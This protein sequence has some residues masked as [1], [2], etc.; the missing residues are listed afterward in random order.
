VLVELKARFDEENNLE[1]AR[2]LERKGV[3]VTYGVEELKIKTHAKISL[4]VRR[5]ANGVRRYVHLGTGNYNAGTA[6]VYTD[7]GLF[8]CN[9]E[10]ADDATRLFNRLTGFAPATSY[11]RL[12]V[13]SDYLLSGLVALIDHEI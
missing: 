4:V 1:W 10:I 12:L 6:R 8:T 9:R 13:A 3:H 2:A 5:E 11:K 7:M